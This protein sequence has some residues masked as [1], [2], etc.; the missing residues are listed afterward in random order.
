[1]RLL[2]MPALSYKRAEPESTI[3]WRISRGEFVPA[4]KTGKRSA[5]FIE[6]EADEI[7]RAEAAGAS[8]EEIKALV[9]RLIAAR[10]AAA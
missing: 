10:R 4:I 3:Y 9:A 8:R 1:M 7:M 6:A 2:K 5:G